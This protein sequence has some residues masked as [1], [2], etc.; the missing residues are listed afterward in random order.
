MLK[1]GIPV[2]FNEQHWMGG[3]N[4]FRNLIVAFSLIEQNDV[5]IILFCEKDD[6]FETTCLNNVRQVIVPHLLSRKL[7]RRILNKIMGVN[8][9]LYSALKKEGIDIL[10]HAQV[11]KRFAYKTLWWKP[12]FQEKYYPEFFTETDIKLRDRAVQYNARNGQ[13]LFSSYDAKNDFFKFYGSISQKPVNVLQFVPEV[14][15]DVSGTD[16]DNIEKVKEKYN[17]R[18][19]YFFL[20]NQFW[21]HKNH[22]LVIEALLAQDDPLQVVATGALN[23]YRGGKHIEFIRSLLAKDINNKFKVLGLIQRD[24]LNY[25]MKGSIAVINPSRFEGWSTT[26]EEAKYLGKRLILSDIPVHH[27]Q[28]PADSL[29]V[30]CDDVKGMITA[31]KTVV[32]EIDPNAENLRAIRAMNDYVLNRKEFGLSFY[33]ILKSL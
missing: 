18:G 31:M 5:E 16:N 28:D 1:V 33:N 12:D 10:S 11:N 26:V 9:A 27:E 15:V 14:K 8:V 22:E 23:D 29:Y 30:Q 21:K 3:I 32:N 2:L 17:I 6:V 7:S 25:L 4:Y 13:L 19:D 24:E 20:P